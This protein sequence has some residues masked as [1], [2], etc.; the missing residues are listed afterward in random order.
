MT[1]GKSYIALSWV[2]T[3]LS[4]ILPVRKPLIS[5]TKGFLLANEHQ[6]PEHL[7]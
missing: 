6:L 2:E 5:E 4:L 3:P 7:V 1:S